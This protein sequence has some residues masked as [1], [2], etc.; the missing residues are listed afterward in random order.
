MTGARRR[1]AGRLGGFAGAVAMNGVASLATIPFVIAHAGVEEWGSI[2]VGQSVGSVMSVFA[3]LGWS[4]TGPA[5]VARASSSERASLYL[6]SLVLRSAAALLLLG[7]SFGISLAL[8]TSS[9]IATWLA[10]SSMILIGVG[11]TWFYVGESRPARLLCFD[12]LPRATSIAVATFFITIDGNIVL[13]SGIILIG[14]L[15]AA[16]A[17]ALDI[18]RR[19]PSSLPLFRDE[20][21][22]RV[23]AGQR[24]AIATATLTTTYQSAPVAIVQM[25]T[26]ALVPAFALLDKIRMQTLTAYRPVSQVFQGWVPNT[27]DTALLHQ[28]A[29]RVLK[30]AVLLGAAGAVIM[31]A[32]APTIVAVLGA[33]KLGVDLPTSIFLGIAFGSAIISITLGPACLI[34]LGRPGTVTLSALTGTVVTFVALISLGTG[35]SVSLVMAAIAIAQTAVAAVQLAGCAK[36]LGEHG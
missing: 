30:T 9:P 15:A 10:S 19:Y 35:A 36:A 14:T 3:L 27:T 31:T 22:L 20:S 11:A 8:G 23:L 24:H 28:R 34:P 16:V 25:L 29:M 18:W 26:P 17:S 7:G 32:A 6:R 2:A 13:Y 4:L 21:P 5:E 12:A 1:F 33:G